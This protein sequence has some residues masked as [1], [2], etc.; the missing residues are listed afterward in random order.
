MP[1]G[2]L[3]PLYDVAVTG[4]RWLVIDEETVLDRPSPSGP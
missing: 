2:S 1:I 4:F 3:K